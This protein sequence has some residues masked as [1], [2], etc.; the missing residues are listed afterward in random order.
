VVSYYFFLFLTRWSINWP[1]S[2]TWFQKTIYIYKVRSPYLIIRVVQCFHWGFTLG[3]LLHYLICWEIYIYISPPSNRCFVKLYLSISKRRKEKKTHGKLTNK[4]W[5]VTKLNVIPSA[6]CLIK[7]NLEPKW[8][9]KFWV[10]ST[11]N[12][13]F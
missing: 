11:K 1:E 13:K 3:E 7:K 6:R 12:Y 8:K 4:F 2:G 5:V 9:S 10:V